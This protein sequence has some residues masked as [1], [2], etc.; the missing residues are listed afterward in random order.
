MTPFDLSVFAAPLTVPELRD[1]P[2][3][4]RGSD[5]SSVSFRN[6]EPS[7]WPAFM[8]VGFAGSCLWR[9]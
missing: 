1:G 4:L 2:I 3:V 9:P 6:Q 8:P 7:H 5:T